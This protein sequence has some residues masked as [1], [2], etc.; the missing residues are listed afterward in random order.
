[1]HLHSNYALMGKC[2]CWGKRG[3]EECLEEESEDKGDKVARDKRLLLYNSDS[4]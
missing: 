1:M 3:W 4:C 2:R